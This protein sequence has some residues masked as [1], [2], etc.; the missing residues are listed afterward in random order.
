MIEDHNFYDTQY[1]TCDKLNGFPNT[2]ILSLNQGFTH[3]CGYTDYI[4]FKN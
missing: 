3:V 2:K 1:N 4:T